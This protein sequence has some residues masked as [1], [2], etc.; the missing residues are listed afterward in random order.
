MFGYVKPILKPEPNYVVLHFGTND[1]IDMI[2]RKILDKLLQQ[3]AAVLDSDENCKIV[4]LF[5]CSQ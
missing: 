2:S 1:A 5:H 3:K 4:S